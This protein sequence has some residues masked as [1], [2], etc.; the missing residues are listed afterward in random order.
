MA[1]DFLTREALASTQLAQLR[2]LLGV[3]L[4]EN[5]FYQRKFSFHHENRVG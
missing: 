5:R 4:P 2:K 3:I 1:G